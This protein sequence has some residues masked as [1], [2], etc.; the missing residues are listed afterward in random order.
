[1]LGAKGPRKQKSLDPFPSVAT[2]RL[3]CTSHPGVR[4]P[5]FRGLGGN[6]PERSGCKSRAKKTMLAACVSSGAGSARR[7]EEAGPTRS[8]AS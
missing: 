3:P 2:Q 4:E 7:E 6:L 8:A 5:G 1:M